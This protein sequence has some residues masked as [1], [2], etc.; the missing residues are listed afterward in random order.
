ITRPESAISG[1]YPPTASSN[2]V[3]DARSSPSFCRKNPV[4]VTAKSVA[5]ILPIKSSRRLARTESPTSNAPARTATAVAKPS[6]TARF[7]RQ[8]YVRFRLTRVEKCIRVGEG[9]RPPFRTSYESGTIALHRELPLPV[10]TRRGGASQEALPRSRRQR[11]D[12]GSRSARRTAVEPARL[13]KPWQ[14]RLAA[15]LH[16]SVGQADGRRGRRAQPDRVK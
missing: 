1:Q 5:P 7:V 16:R 4:E 12:Q 10:S 11:G 2:S 9:S 6:T 14:P 15:F 3:L 13:S 8:K